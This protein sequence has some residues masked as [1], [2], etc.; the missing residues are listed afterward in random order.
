MEF[1]TYRVRRE[2]SSVDIVAETPEDAVRRVHDLSCFAGWTDP[3]PSFAVFEITGFDT[4]RSRLRPYSRRYTEE[5]KMRLGAQTRYIKTVTLD[6][7][8]LKA[9]GAVG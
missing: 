9:R 8:T 2:G 6:R 1:K 3:E 4:E 5:E 7:S